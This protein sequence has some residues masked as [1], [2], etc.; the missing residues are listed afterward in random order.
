MSYFLARPPQGRPSSPQRKDPPRWRIVPNPPLSPPEGARSRLEVKPPH[1]TWAPP[2]SNFTTKDVTVGNRPM[3]GLQ[4]GQ[5]VCPNRRSNRKQTR[6]LWPNPEP[7]RAAARRTPSERT[8]PQGDLSLGSSLSG[9]SHLPDMT[10]WLMVSF[11]TLYK[12]MFVELI[13][14][15]SII[16]LI[17]VRNQ[18]HMILW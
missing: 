10:S 12:V 6:K 7:H 9:N 8:I 3:P 16:F 13:K 2:P 11:L 4:S 5:E 1:S 15:I 17:K 14:S 18:K